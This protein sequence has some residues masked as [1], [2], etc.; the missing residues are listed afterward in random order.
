MFAFVAM[1]TSFLYKVE[2]LN[3][4]ERGPIIPVKIG[5]NS[6][7]LSRGKILLT[8]DGRKDGWLQGQTDVR[9]T[10]YDHNVS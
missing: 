10:S 6:A 5:E 7:Q 4:S 8:V 9:K 3:N 1:A 2:F